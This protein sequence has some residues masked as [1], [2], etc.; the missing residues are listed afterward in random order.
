M[1]GWVDRWVGGCQ[2]GKQWVMVGG[3]WGVE[4]WMQRFQVTFSL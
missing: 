2:M 4:G 1:K 3:L